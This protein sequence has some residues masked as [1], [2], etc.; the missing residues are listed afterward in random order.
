MKHSDYKIPIL[1][2][3]SDSH[4]SFHFGRNRSKLNLVHLIRTNEFTTFL[5]SYL[6]LSGEFVLIGLLVVAI[7]QAKARKWTKSE[8]QERH[9]SE[10]GSLASE[11]SSDYQAPT[12][13]SWIASHLVE[14]LIWVVWLGLAN[15][16]L[17]AS[18]LILSHTTTQRHS[19]HSYASS[20]THDLI[21]QLAHWLY[22]DWFNY[23]HS[24]SSH[25]RIFSQKWIAV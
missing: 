6:V 14:S 17:T 20:W 19:K 2:I 15:R 11:L 13:E 22:W 7:S 5:V 25:D 18:E 10:S 16:S 9:P 21:R 4:E 8:N 1:G 24:L 23:R 3:D 12:R